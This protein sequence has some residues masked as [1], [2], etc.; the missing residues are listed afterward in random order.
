MKLIAK[1]FK[2][3][4]AGEYVDFLIENPDLIN[5]INFMIL[6]SVVRNGDI[7]VVP[8]FSYGPTPLN[9][10]IDK[11]RNVITNFADR[12]DADEWDD[13][14]IINVMNIHK[15]VDAALAQLG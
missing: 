5:S 3:E 2:R 12:I 7:E 6:K 14:H 4:A 15:E 8:F 11:D 10:N 1:G 13:I 9:L